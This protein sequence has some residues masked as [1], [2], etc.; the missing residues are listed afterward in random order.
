[1]KVLEIPFNESISARILNSMDQ[2]F[3]IWGEPAYSA[4]EIYQNLNYRKALLQTMFLL[5]EI[6]GI[7]RIHMYYNFDA[8]MITVN[9]QGIIIGIIN[10]PAKADIQ[11]ISEIHANSPG[12]YILAKPGFSKQFALKPGHSVI[13]LEKVESGNLSETTVESID[14]PDESTEGII[15]AILSDRTGQGLRSR[16]PHV[17]VWYNDLL[18]IVSKLSFPGYCA[19]GPASEA[20]FKAC[21]QLKALGIEPVLREAVYR[22]V[23]MSNL[24]SITARDT[25]WGMENQGKFVQTNM[26]N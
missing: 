4:V 18:F 14:K 3:I 21:E 7:N 15:E 6:P 9:E 8:E 5:P 24:H 16:I 10:I 20:V 23:F 26:T 22:R 12:F 19:S 2:E 25:W 13:R 1:M 11:L 17:Y